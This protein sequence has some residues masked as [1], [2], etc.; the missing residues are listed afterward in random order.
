[1]TGIDADPAVRES[2]RQ[3]CD[4]F[5]DGDVEDPATRDPIRGPFDAVVMADVLEHLRRPEVVLRH[6]RRRWLA[7]SGRLI[8]SVPNSAHWAFRREIL[9]GRFPR[10]DLGLFDR[11]H[12]HFYSRDTLG[13]LLATE[14]FLVEQEAVTVNPNS[15]GELTFRCLAPFYRRST[16]R[17]A[18]LAAERILSRR[19]PRL[20]GYQFVLRLAARRGAG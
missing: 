18:L 20:F 16:P 17:R 19:L 2:A 13:D 3:A 6:V 4:R 8:L 14:G 7:P 5:V 15:H 11:D 12:L 1:V 9:A 10:R